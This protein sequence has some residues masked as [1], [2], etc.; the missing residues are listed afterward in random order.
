VEHFRPVSRAA[1]H[2][3]NYRNHRRVL[4]VDGRVGFTGGS[5]VGWEWMG[6]GLGERWRDTDVRVAGP[7]VRQIQGAFAENWFEATGVL[8]G[9]EAYYPPS[10]MAGDVRAQAVRS[11]PVDGNVSM[12]SLFLLAITAA[13]RSIHITNQYLVLDDALTAALVG[14]ARRGVEVRLILP[15]QPTNP[16]VH[17]AGHRDV[18]RLLAAGIE[19]YGYTAGRLHAKTMVVDRRWATVGSTNLDP[20]SFALNDELN[21]V[22]YDD[23][24]ARRLEAIFAEDLAR[25]R[26]ITRAEWEDTPLGVRLLGLLLTPFRG[27]L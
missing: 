13:R 1:L 12:Y 5:G 11:A 25:S 3:F 26:P 21:L 17:A 7:V 27:Q 20:R 2:R 19:L 22:A 18:G 14:A 4:V 10:V 6:N 16:L 9:G 15:G 24:V 23:V 8:L